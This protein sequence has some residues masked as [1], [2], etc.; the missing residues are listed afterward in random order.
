MISFD[1]I[2]FL[3]ISMGFAWFRLMLLDFVDSAGFQMIF[4][5]F[6]MISHA[7][8]QVYRISHDFAGV[9]MI[10]YG[11][12]GS[13]DTRTCSVQSIW[14]AQCRF[15]LPVGFLRLLNLRF[16]HCDVLEFWSFE[17]SNCW[18]LGI[19]FFESWHFESL[20]FWNFERLT[21]KI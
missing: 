11:F 21:S 18:K 1:F 6:H 5:W 17:S 19:C 2:W 8:T 12:I 7:F 14:F 9:R 16:G 3:M 13:S 20:Q 15:V 4:K 10:S